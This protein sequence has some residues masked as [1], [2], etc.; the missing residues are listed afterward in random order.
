[1]TILSGR[2]RETSRA[3]RG[4]D[5]RWPQAMPRVGERILVTQSPC[6][7]DAS[8]RALSKEVTEKESR[9]GRARVPTVD[10]YLRPMRGAIGLLCDSRLPA[11]KC[12]VPPLNRVRISLPFSKG[13]HFGGCDGGQGHAP[14]LIPSRGWPCWHSCRR[15]WVAWVTTVLLGAT[16]KAQTW[17]KLESW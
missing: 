9:S 12:P 17:L 3:L 5:A 1:M 10:I 2:T 6:A 11:E 14:E 7:C 13:A 15:C 16:G 4:D 8:L